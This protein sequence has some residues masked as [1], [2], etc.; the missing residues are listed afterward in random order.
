LLKRCH[1]YY[2]SIFH[3]VGRTM[4]RMQLDFGVSDLEPRPVP[5]KS[6]S[7]SVVYH[8]DKRSLFSADQLFITDGRKTKQLQGPDELNE[9][10]SP[11]SIT[12][13]ATTTSASQLSSASREVSGIDLA[14]IL[15]GSRH[16]LD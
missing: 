16:R 4:P 11:S 13:S 1:T 6:P 8:A 7:K 10:R 9:P 12:T 5:R 3:I 14:K 15:L 2:S